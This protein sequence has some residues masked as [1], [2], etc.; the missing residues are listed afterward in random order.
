V[1]AQ[2]QAVVSLESR[3]I[4][5]DLASD[6]WLAPLQPTLLSNYSN[7]PACPRANLSRSVDAN[8]YQL[9]VTLTDGRGSMTQ[10]TVDVVPTC[11]TGAAAALCHC[12]CAQGY[13]LGMPCN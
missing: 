4:F 11:P 7:L 6:G 1:D 13:M 10:T 2:T 9:K 3:P 5:L 8:T 12:Q